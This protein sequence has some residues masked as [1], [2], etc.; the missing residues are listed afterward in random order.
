MSVHRSK[1]KR[2]LT[3]EQQQE[4]RKAFE[5]FD[6]D[7]SGAIDADELS[8]AMKTLGFTTK[9]EEIIAMIAE[10]DNDGSGT[11]EYKEFEQMMAKLM[12]GPAPD[13]DEDDKKKAKKVHTLQGNAF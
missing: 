11:V 12:L 3:E 5:V 7:K 4:I 6:A 9:M 10:V 2:N 8:C 1:K 13:D